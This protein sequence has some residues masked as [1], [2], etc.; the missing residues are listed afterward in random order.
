MDF[1]SLR[2]SFVQAQAQIMND[3]K[4]EPVVVISKDLA[5][6]LVDKLAAIDA[7][8]QK[9]LHDPELSRAGSLIYAS[10]I[11]RVLHPKDGV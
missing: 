11:H 9:A 8:V 3:G 7:M 10:E 4:Y 6:T 5:L 2:A 1:T